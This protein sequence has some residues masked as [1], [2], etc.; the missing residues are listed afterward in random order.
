MLRITKSKRYRRETNYFLHGQR[1]QAK[2][3]AK[4]IAK[5]LGVTISDDLQWEKHTQATAA[6]A[7][8][9]IGFLRNCSKQNRDT[10]YK[11]MIRPTTEYASTSWDPYKVED[12]NLVLTRSN[13]ELHVMLATFTQNE[14]QDASQQWLAH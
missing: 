2:D 3:S 6:K 14:P 11:S 5:Y 8:C 13:V 1:L 12:V 10:T 7:S 4:Y 9:T